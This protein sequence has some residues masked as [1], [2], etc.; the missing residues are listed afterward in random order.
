MNTDRKR[1]ALR[2]IK[3][4]WIQRFVSIIL[5]FGVRTVLI[6][7]LNAQYAGLSSLFASI[8]S[9]LSLT[10]LGFSN[11]IVYSMYKPI[12]DDDEKKICALLNLYRKAY[13]I[14]GTIILLLGSVLIPI[15]PLLIKGDVPNDTNI[16]ILYGIYLINSALSYFL[17]GYKTSLLSAHQREDIISKNTLLYT[18]LLNVIQCV[19]LLCY[20]NYYLYTIIIPLSTVLLNLLNNHTVNRVYP[21]YK[22][23]GILKSEEKAELKRNI[24]GLMIWKIGGATRNTFDS[25]VVSMYLGLIT[26][27]MYNNYFFIITGVN[28]FLGVIVTSITAGVGN[29]IVTDSPER[30]YMDFRKF[31]FYYNWIAGLSTV[32][33]M[34]LFQP[35]MQLW[36]GRELVFPN[37]IMILFSFYFFMMQQGSI[38][39]VYYHAAGLW[40]HGRFRSIIEA[41]LNI[42]LNFILGKYYGVSGI[43]IATIISFTLVNV[44]GSKFVFTMYFKN[45]G[46]LHYF[47]DN[48]F[49]LLVVAISGFLSFVFLDKVSELLGANLIIKMFLGI[50]ICITLPNALFLTIFS[51][52]KIY[53]GYI[54]QPLSQ[55]MNKV[56]WCRSNE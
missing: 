44:Y 12:A 30:N 52:F 45:K 25:I 34:C 56:E 29:K 21:K 20:R 17:Y 1:N 35:F 31:Q 24:M 22:P 43:I 15:L 36:M 37:S 32:F 19:I 50:I 26:V 51:R 9:I 14:I 55:I 11:A 18:V 3:W 39:A 46:F 27:A 40:W 13:W 38:N 6:Y 10:E 5:P 49:F 54:Q 53:Y 41:A 48:Y 28:A 23:Y 2:N 7:V 16:Y 47:A 33:M 4:G 8:L 42:I